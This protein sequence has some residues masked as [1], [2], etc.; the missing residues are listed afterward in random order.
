M[1][2]IGATPGDSVVMLFTSFVLAMLFSLIMTV[3]VNVILTYLL[4]VGHVDRRA[5]IGD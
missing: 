2:L 4:F 5:R 1:G 3:R